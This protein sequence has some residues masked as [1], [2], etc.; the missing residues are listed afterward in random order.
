MSWRWQGRSLYSHLSPV[1]QNPGVFLSCLILFLVEKSLTNINCLLACLLVC[2]QGQKNIE[3][4][5][6]PWK[7]FEDGKHE[8]E[9]HSLVG[10]LK[11]AMWPVPTSGVKETSNFYFFLRNVFKRF[12]SM[13]NTNLRFI[14]LWNHSE[15]SCDRPSLPGSK[16]HQIFI[17]CA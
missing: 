14:Q 9:V 6:F 8:S 17:F 11:G 1:W 13:G 2:P 12:S 15:G 7:V 3:I 4:Q 10:S 5:L 16:K